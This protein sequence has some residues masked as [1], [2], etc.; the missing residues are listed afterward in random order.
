MKCDQ[1]QDMMVNQYAEEKVGSIDQAAVDKHMASC[2]ECRDFK[3][4]VNK[5]KDIFQ[6]ATAVQPE[7]AVWLGIAERLAPQPAWWTSWHFWPRPAFAFAVFASALI[8]IGVLW[9]PLPVTKTAARHDDF[10]GVVLAS[11]VNVEEEIENNG[12]GSVIED[13]WL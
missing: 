13:V 10:A 9:Q 5:T 6:T 12:F 4:A 8:V 3:T 11:N 1:I 7:P 2:A